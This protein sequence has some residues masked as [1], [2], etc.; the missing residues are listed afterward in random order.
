MV[1]AGIGQNTEVKANYAESHKDDQNQDT[2]LHL[3]NP[4][5]IPTVSKKS[6][7]VSQQ[8]VS[9]HYRYQTKT[10]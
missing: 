2:S 4:N 3:N 6:L 1:V 8:D 9:P 5:D 10:G 7:V